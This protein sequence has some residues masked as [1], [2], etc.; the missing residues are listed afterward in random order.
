MTVSDVAPPAEPSGDRHWML[1]AARGDI[2]T[3][4]ALDMVRS[5]RLT[6]NLEATDPELAA[7]LAA[8]DKAHPDDN[9]RNTNG[10]APWL[11]DIDPD[12]ATTEAFA[13]IT[14]NGLDPGDYY[15]DPELDQFLDTDDPDY[16][17]L[18]DGLIERQDRVIVTGEEGR[19]KSTLLRQIGIQLASGVHPFTLDA[20]DPLQVLLVDCENSARQVRR[21]LRALRPPAETYVEGRLRLRVLG[22][23]LELA[24]PEIQDDLA[25]RIETQQVDVL[26]IGPLYKLIDDDPVKEVPARKVADALDRLRQIVGTAL[27]IEAHSPYAEGNGKK[28]PIRPYG[29]S[30]WSR[31]PEFGIHLGELGELTHWR[32][33]REERA[34]PAKLRWDQPWPWGV[35]KDGRETEEWN[36]PTECVAAIVELLETTGDEL[37]RTQIQKELKERNR[38]YGNDTIQDALR[39]AVMNGRLG[40]RKGPRKS[41]LYRFLTVPDRSGP[42]PEN[43]EEMPWF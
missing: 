18:V 15:V 26:I 12:P 25:I 7:A 35:D 13:Q 37:N 36:G 40:H 30:L 29:A 17:W 6:P 33:Q 42:F 38:S 43:G 27:L 20:I 24:N 21:K 9:R 32:G 28:R 10:N 2:D 39:I 19:G 3:D 5:I 4:A 41:D 14:S 11:L 34:W 31:W 22:H 23:A 8:G 1:Q 16:D